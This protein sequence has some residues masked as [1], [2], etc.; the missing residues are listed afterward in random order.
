MMKR[1]KF[2][3]GLVIVGIIASLAL[4]IDA[5][6]QKPFEIWNATY[7]GGSDDHAY[8]VALDSKDNIIVTGHSYLG[9]DRDYYTIKYDSN[10]TALW[11]MAY[12]GE[13]FADT[14][15]SVAV[16]S[17]DNI[18]VTG[19]SDLG[20]N[21]GYH[22]VKYNGSG[23]ELWNVTSDGG[24]DK[25]AFSVAVDSK[26]NI[27]VTGYSSTDAG[28]LN[29]YTIKYNSSGSELW[30]MTDDGGSDDGA[31]SVAVDSKDNIILTGLSDLGGDFDYYTIKYNSSGSELWN[32]TYDGGSDDAASTVTVD[33]KDNIIISGRSDLGGYWNYY[34]IKYDSKGF[35]LWNATYDGG[36]DD[37]AW[38]V[39]V[40][41]KDNIIVTGDSYLREMNYY[42][43]KYDSSGSEL[44]NATYDGGSDDEAW[45][46]AVDSKDNIIVTGYSFSGLLGTEDYYTIKYNSHLSAGVIC[47]E[48]KTPGFE[49]IFAFGDV[50]V[51]AYLVLRKMK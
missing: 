20:G 34:T 39:A 7:D 25:G 43:I 40:D 26:D 8:C 9:G 33:S 44:W 29:Y 50:L 5:N 35:E 22:T 23:F 11:N 32:A 12:D 42:T 13:G 17:M 45:S 36:S 46:V 10:G 18:I 2:V 51:V 6:A 28:N 4:T 1:I 16:D 21:G 3:C 37:E 15:F 41:S 19:I 49:V 14:A 30:N 47:G 27:I 31:W 38:S 48:Q 24:S